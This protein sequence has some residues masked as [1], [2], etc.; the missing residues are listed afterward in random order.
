[1]TPTKDDTAIVM[2]DIGPALAIGMF[3]LSAKSVG[4]Q[5]FV[6]HPGRLGTAK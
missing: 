4:N 6:A 1:M 2:V 5:F 3:K